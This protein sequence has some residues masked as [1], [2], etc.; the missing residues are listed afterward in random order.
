MKIL[1]SLL[2][3]TFSISGLLANDELI[4]K[5]VYNGKCESK[6]VQMTKE[7][8]GWMDETH[9]VWLENGYILDQQ[10]LHVKKCDELLDT[11]CT[12]CK[13]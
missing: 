2:L 4:E 7:Q 9:Y 12:K 10:P 6:K 11:L 3:I 13:E 8:H 5:T 1:S